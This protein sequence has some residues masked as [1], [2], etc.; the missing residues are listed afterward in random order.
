MTPAEPDAAAVQQAAPSDAG[1]IADSDDSD[2]QIGA[3]SA[4][5][6]ES[7][8]DEEDQLL[9]SQDV[10][11]LHLQAGA[12]HIVAD[13]CRCGVCT[14]GC[15]VRCTAGNHQQYRRTAGEDGCLPLPEDEEE[16]DDA[17]LESSDEVGIRH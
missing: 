6:S 3:S 13:I 7:S 11:R 12:L 8:S 16:L 17:D 15:H 4:S 9:R 5:A 2:F 10:Q 14:A 1:S